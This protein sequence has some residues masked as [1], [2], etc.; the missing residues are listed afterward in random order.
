MSEFFRR[1]NPG[2]KPKQQP[3]QSSFNKK[4]L[5]LKSNLRD[6]ALNNDSSVTQSQIEQDDSHY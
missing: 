4:N 5:D 3:K 6:S 2:P 1:L